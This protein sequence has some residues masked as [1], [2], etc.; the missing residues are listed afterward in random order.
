MK[1]YNRFMEMFWLV[2]S[3]MSAIGVVYFYFFE[4][5]NEH[6]IILFVPFTA[7]ILFIIRRWFRKRIEDDNKAGKF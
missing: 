6:P 4:G 7:F 2:I 5:L 3:V 1:K